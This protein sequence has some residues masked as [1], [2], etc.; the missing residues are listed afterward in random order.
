MKPKVYV[1]TWGCQMNEYDSARMVDVLAQTR[2]AVA[3]S[4]PEDAD[5]L[6][7]NTCSVREKAQEKLFSQLGRW[8]QLKAARPD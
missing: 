2:G 8:R 6:I 4:R 7:L 1:Q 5:I 3:A